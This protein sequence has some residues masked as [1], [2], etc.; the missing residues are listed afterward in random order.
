MKHQMILLILKKI[1]NVTLRSKRCASA[2]RDKVRE[3]SE[4]VKSTKTSFPE[5][6][7]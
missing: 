6:K 7:F 4:L 2:K 3:R 1:T 5:A